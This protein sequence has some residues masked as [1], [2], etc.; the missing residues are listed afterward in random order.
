M[1][2]IKSEGTKVSKDENVFRYYSNN[3]SSLKEQIAELDIQIGN[4]IEG[5]TK[6]Y[7]AD[8]QVLDKQIETYLSKVLS[9]NNIVDLNE[10][11]SNIADILI[12]KAKIVGELSPSGAHINSLIEQRRKLEE[13]LNNGQEY[14]KAPMSGVVSYKVDN[15]EEELSPNN[16]EN[17]NKELLESYN[18]KTGQ[19]V[20]TN[21]EKRKNCQ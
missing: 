13:E 18:L 19:L 20:P 2:E 17:F 12:K 10:Y 9:T 15:L 7:S 16:F 4:A 8:I 5:Q 11:K 21:V 14:I 3:E 1:A 6:V